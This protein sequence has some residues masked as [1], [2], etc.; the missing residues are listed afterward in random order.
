LYTDLTWK[1]FFAVDSE[2]L[3]QL[4]P[5]QIVPA[6]LL[7]HDVY[8][9]LIEF[10][11][12]KSFYD[13]RLQ[14]W[15]SK[16]ALTIERSEFKI[17]EI[18][19]KPYFVKDLFAEAKIVYRQNSNSMEA[20]QF[21]GKI[22]KIINSNGKENIGQMFT[23]NLDQAVLLI[24]KTARLFSEI[25]PVEVRLAIDS[26]YKD[27]AEQ[28]DQLLKELIIQN[29][30]KEE[31]K[32][33]KTNPDNKAESMKF[34]NKLNP[35]K[36]K[37]NTLPTGSDS[38]SAPQALVKPSSV[39]KKNDQKTDEPKKLSYEDIRKRIENSFAKDKDG[40]FVNLSDVLAE[41]QKMAVNQKDARI[42]D[43]Y[44]FNEGKGIF[45]WNESMF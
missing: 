2:K 7:E 34:L 29:N 36:K 24:V 18:D 26:Y 33:E 39:L 6:A 25:K 37:E 38:I 23:E 20:A 4:I 5:R 15:F 21:L 14:N 40:N 41:L 44:I 32:P 22:K 8:G 3:L 45:E 31:K 43:L 30:K 9:R 27:V 28:E 19:G 12:K 11:D 35:L 10:L 13:E 17:G 1:L 42:R 16:M